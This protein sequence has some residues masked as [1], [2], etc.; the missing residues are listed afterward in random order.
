[1][2]SSRSH[3]PLKFL[4][5]HLTAFKASGNRRSWRNGRTLNLEL[6]DSRVCLSA[7]GF[8]THVLTRFF[9]AW[10][11]VLIAFSGDAN[12]VGFS[13][14]QSSPYRNRRKPGM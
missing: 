11:K 14:V 13:E 10:R 12:C 7:L 9:R 4:V 3:G 5:A 6:L 1:M 8:D 2:D